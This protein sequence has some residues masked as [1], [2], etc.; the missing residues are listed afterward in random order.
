M[1]AFW[2]ASLMLIEICDVFQL[3][4]KGQDNLLML[5]ARNTV[6]KHHFLGT[7]LLIIIYKVCLHYMRKYDYYA[8]L[9]EILKYL[10]A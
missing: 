2:F 4:A 7:V 1:K 3:K 9:V 10:E 6:L 5:F 8:A